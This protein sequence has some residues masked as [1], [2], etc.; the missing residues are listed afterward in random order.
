MKAIIIS[1]LNKAYNP[2]GRWTGTKFL[3]LLGIESFMCK[4]TGELTFSFVHLIVA[5]L[6]LYIEYG[7]VATWEILEG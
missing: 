7:I 5:E 6:L 2:H 4:E 3:R 1:L